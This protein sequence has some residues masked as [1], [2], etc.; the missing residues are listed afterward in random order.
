MKAFLITMI[1]V[2]ILEVVVE[3][4]LVEGATKKYIQAAMS[5]VVLLTFLCQLAIFIKKDYSLPNF[6]EDIQNVSAIDENILSKLQIME[7]NGAIDNIEN[8]LESNGL[9]NMFINFSYIFNADGTVSVQNIFVD[10]SNLVINKNAENININEK[11]IQ[12]CRN[13]ISIDEERIIINGK[14]EQ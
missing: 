2:V 6:S 5:L 11:I 1:A 10:T 9:E 3:I 14:E 7:Y 13:Y 12:C 4:I 8:E